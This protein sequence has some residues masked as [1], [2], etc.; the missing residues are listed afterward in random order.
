MTTTEQER[1]RVMSQTQKLIRLVKDCQQDL[2]QYLPHDSVITKD[3]IISRLLARLD[4]PQAR[5]A[6]VGEAIQ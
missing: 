6:L 3:E 1:E 2:A 5:E 4:G